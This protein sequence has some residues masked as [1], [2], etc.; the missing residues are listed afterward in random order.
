MNHQERAKA[1]VA[2]MMEHDAFSQ[3]LGIEVL[4]VAPG[5][6]TVRMGVRAEMLN[7]HGN[8]HGGISYSLADSCFAFSS[9]SHGYY[10]VSIETSIAHTR[11]VKQ[12]DTLTAVSEELQVGKTLGRYT[13]TVTN[14]DQKQVAIFHG[15]VFKDGR[16]W[17]LGE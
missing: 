15:T 11:P 5:T 2:K 10:A 17:E 3:W 1:V 6:C 13:I 14:Q 8:A 12:G 4:E 16:K 9:N 7:G